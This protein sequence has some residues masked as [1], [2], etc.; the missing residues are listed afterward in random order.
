MKFKPGQLI[1]IIGTIDTAPDGT[2]IQALSPQ[3]I[4]KLALIVSYNC[5]NL[6]YH[7]MVGN[8]QDTLE[9]YEE[10]VKLING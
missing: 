6:L 3:Y 7:V 4:G 8:D 5:E 1:E 9:V 2:A 10:E